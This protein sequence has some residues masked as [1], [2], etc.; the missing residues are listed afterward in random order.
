VTTVAA[1]TH[2]AP[3]GQHL[4]SIE[5]VALGKAARTS[6]PRAAHEGWQAPTS[7][8]DPVELLESQAASRVQDL[9]PIR[10]GRMLVSPFTFFR[11]AALIMASDL[12]STPR[13]GFDVQACGDAHL[14][15]FGVFASAERSL[16]FDLND[17]DE[18]LP[19]PWEWDVKRLAASLAIAGR[20]RGFSD[21]ERSSVVLEA[22]S[23]YRKEMAA[24]AV[25]RDLDVWY[26]R[27]DIERV[28]QDLGGEL[29]LKGAAKSAD[30]TMSKAK[31][32]ADKLLVKARTRDSMQALEKLTEVVDGETRFVSDPPLIVP[33]AELMPEAEGALLT[34]R[35]HELLQSYSGTLQSDRRHLL[36]QFRFVSIARKVVGVGSVGTRAWVLL[37]VGSDGTDPLLL[38]AKEAQESVLARFVGDS[39][40][41]NQGERVVAGQHLM[42]ASSDIFLG[43][44]RVE[45]ID[46]VQRDFYIRQLRDWKG[47]ADTDVMIPQAMAI[48]GRLCGWTL[49]RAHARSGDRIAIAAYLG[50]SKAFDNAIASFAEAYADQ[51]ERDYDALKKAAADGRIVVESGL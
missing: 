4:T 35:M 5:R 3:S 17:F 14:S 22:V 20:D 10:Y 27:M 16:V 12:A 36:D 9:V 8:P 7:R 15:N 31:S 49:A 24:L 37:L 32:H 29:G 46:G 21:K 2:A 38:Q 28:L 43:W 1:P 18:T 45:G 25:K 44:D 39:L 41:A 23:G 19:G 13:S 40:H 6:A 11:G 33:I 47:S 26:A 51:N 42:Q 50:S 30:R 34:D 48:Y